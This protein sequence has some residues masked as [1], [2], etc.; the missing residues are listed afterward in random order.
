MKIPTHIRYT[1]CPDHTSSCQNVIFF[2]LFFYFLMIFLIGHTRR[3][4]WVYFLMIFLIGQTRRTMWVGSI[5]ST[6]ILNRSLICVEWTF[7][8]V[9][10]I[11]VICIPTV[12]AS[13]A[14]RHTECA[15]LTYNNYNSVCLYM[16]VYIYIPVSELLIVTCHLL[17]SGTL[18]IFFPRD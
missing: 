11:S 15:G 3:T 6:N 9:S 13:I 16:I 10:N 17:S 18:E 5:T 8:S 12:Y 7:L 14:V 2:I 4:M 1:T